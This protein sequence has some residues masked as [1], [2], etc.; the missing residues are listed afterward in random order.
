MRVA[1]CLLVIAIWNMTWPKRRK[2][3]GAGKEAKRQSACSVKVKT[4]IV[5]C[6]PSCTKLLDDQPGFLFWVVY[7]RNHRHVTGLPSIHW[8]GEWGFLK[9]KYLSKKELKKRCLS[10]NIEISFFIFL[11]EPT[12]RFKFT[13]TFYYT[14]LNVSFFFYKKFECFFN[15]IIK[16]N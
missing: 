1:F 8:P 15:S 9:E 12:Q 7:P 5:K 4:K 3:M 14:S 13:G 10:A 16:S 11:Y 6:P 2:V